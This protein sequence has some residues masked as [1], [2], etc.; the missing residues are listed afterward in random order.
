MNK[1]FLSLVSFLLLLP[2][3]AV[4]QDLT[5]TRNFSGLWDQPE[6]ESQGINLQVVD[7]TSGDKLAVAYWFTYGDDMKSA[8][9]MGV[10]PASSN[11]IA[12]RGFVAPLARIL[13]CGSER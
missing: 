1:Q 12:V 3:F 2:A 6:H 11:R 13:R 9:F 5:V 7:R 10:G 4:A 8:W